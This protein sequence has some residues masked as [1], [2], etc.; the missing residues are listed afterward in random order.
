[1]GVLVMMTSMAAS[2]A[3]ALTA[4]VSYAD[5]DLSKTAGAA[6]LY[7]RLQAASHAVC[8][9]VLDRD[10]RAIALADQCTA[11]ALDRAVAGLHAPI[12]SE[13]HHGASSL[14]RVAS[15]D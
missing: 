12:V 11:D 14:E 8:K 4:R 7:R 5:V 1:M 9:P 6:I 10:L 3:D 15:R 13:M 2:A